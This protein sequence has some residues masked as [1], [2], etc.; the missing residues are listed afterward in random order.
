MKTLALVLV[1]TFVCFIAVGM[2]EEVVEDEEPE[3][4]VIT[5]DPPNKPTDCIVVQVCNS[6]GDCEWRVSCP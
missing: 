6:N 3:Y 1:I 4:I 5:P 2:A